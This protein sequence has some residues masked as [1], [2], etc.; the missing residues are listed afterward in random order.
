MSLLGRGEGE[1]LITVTL[2]IELTNNNG[3]RTQHFAKSA[4]FRR[5]VELQLRGLGHVYSPL[6]YPVWY[7]VTRILGKRQKFWDQSSGLRGNWKEIED[8]MVACGWFKDDSYEWVREV[9]FDQ[10]KPQEPKLPAV[11]IELFAVL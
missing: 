6:P 1:P 2:P 10:F 8:A 11:K 5:K 7:R 9:R 4:S 3:G